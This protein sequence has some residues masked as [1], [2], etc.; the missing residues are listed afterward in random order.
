MYGT[1]KHRDKSPQS[2]SFT[3]REIQGKKWEEKKIL[4]PN[5]RSATVVEGR[6]ITVG[7]VEGVD[8][9]VLTTMVRKGEDGTT[10]L[11]PR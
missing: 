9:K 2:E 8:D 5:S 11:V 10:L 3:E 7:G 6:D 4:I 1:V